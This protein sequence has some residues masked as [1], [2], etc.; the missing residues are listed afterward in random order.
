MNQLLLW[1]SQLQM[2]KNFSS[3][4]FSYSRINSTF[5]SKSWQLTRLLSVSWPTRGKGGGGYDG[6]SPL[7]QA[8]NAP[9]GAAP[10]SVGGLPSNPPSLQ[11]QD[12]ECQQ[13]GTKASP[14]W[15]PQGKPHGLVVKLEPSP[16]SGL[17][18]GGGSWG[19]FAQ[20]LSILF[21]HMT[22]AGEFPMASHFKPVLSN[23]C[24]I[25]PGRKGCFRTNQPTNRRGH[26]PN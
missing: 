24:L 11:G 26:S 9:E 25:H 22:T 16:G 1:L 23:S 14:A 12:Q 6:P 2:P 19:Q 20:I 5:C 4:L 10:P 18:G 21:I 13:G 8:V 15:P 3:Q 7:C 17:R